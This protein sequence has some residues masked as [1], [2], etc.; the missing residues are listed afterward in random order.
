ML[1]LVLT[2]PQKYGIAPHTPAVDS[3]R[4]GYGLPHLFVKTRISFSKTGQIDEYSVKIA[5]TVVN[6]TLGEAR[7]NLQ[8]VVRPFPSLC[9]KE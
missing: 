4:R 8:V 1:A 2:H 7:A 9:L 3:R 6:G 5:E